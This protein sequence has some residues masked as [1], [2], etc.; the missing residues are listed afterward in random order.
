MMSLVVSPTAGLI[1]KSCIVVGQLNCS[2]VDL[3]SKL[4]YFQKNSNPIRLTV[5]L[6]LNTKLNLTLTLTLHHKLTLRK[7]KVKKIKRVTVYIAQ[8]PLASISL[9][10]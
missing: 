2:I 7:P 9:R 8:L 1:Y 6:K 5:T 10:E 3:L 4:N